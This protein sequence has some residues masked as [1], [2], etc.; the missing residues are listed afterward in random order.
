MT[1]NSFHYG[2]DNRAGNPI[3]CSSLYYIYEKKGFCIQVGCISDAN[4]EYGHEISK[5]VR[6]YVRAAFVGIKNISF[7]WNN[8]EWISF[9]NIFFDKLQDYITDLIR[10]LDVEHYIDSTGMIYNTLSGSIVNSGT[11]LTIIVHVTKNTGHTDIF[12]A[13]VG[14]SNALIIYYDSKDTMYEQLN[15]DHSIGKNQS[16]FLRIQNLSNELYPEKYQFIYDCRKN[17]QPID[18]WPHIYSKTGDFNNMSP[19]MMS[20]YGLQYDG[21]NGDYKMGAFTKSLNNCLMPYTRSIGF[22]NERRFGITH[23]PS[24]KHQI[25]DRSKNFV[26]V[27]SLNS[28][29]NSW[30]TVDFV[31]KYCNLLKIHNIRDASKIIF[32]SSICNSL[33]CY[34]GVENMPLVTWGNVK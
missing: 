4:G 2:V 34:G 3:C 29:W 13:S 30:N 33:L 28:L 6:N 1:S 20:F 14:N 10:K 9:L 18:Q 21:L 26:I 7:E 12:T 27:M 11:S 25:V 23:T 5:T 8:S 15:E 16:E 22:L 24:I 17:K 19:H 32:E 31:S